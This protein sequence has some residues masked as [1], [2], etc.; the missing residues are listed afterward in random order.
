MEVAFVCQ[1][2]VHKPVEPGKE[3][4]LTRDDVSTRIIYSANG[5]LVFVSTIIMHLSITVNPGGWAPPS[6]VRT[7]AKREITKFL[8]K[9]STTC[10]NAL[11]N[12]PLTL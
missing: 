2:L 7:I 1:T 4:E 5:K 12:S 10:H 8:K 9:I 3:S 11:C 6:V